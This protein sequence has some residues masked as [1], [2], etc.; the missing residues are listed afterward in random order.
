[1]TTKTDVADLV[2][3]LQALTDE[4]APKMAS[5]RARFIAR[6]EAVIDS[7]RA[8]I[9]LDGDGEL[10]NAAGTWEAETGGLAGDVEEYIG[11]AWGRLVG[12]DEDA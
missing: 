3:E 10:F 4:V 12:E 6:C 9:D 8:L 2:A 5:I 7:P 11:G 1:M